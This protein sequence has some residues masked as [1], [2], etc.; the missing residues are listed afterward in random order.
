MTT[1]KTPNKVVKISAYSTMAGAFLTLANESQA[2]VIY[3]NI[4]D[5]TYTAIGWYG[6]DA[7]DNGYPDFL[8]QAVS[9]EGGN[10]TFASA[11]GAL[12]S[13]GYGNDANMVVGY[14]GDVHYYGSALNAGELIG[15]LSPFADNTY[16]R[17]WLASVYSGSTYGQFGNTGDRFMGFKFDIDG[18]LHYGWARL[19]ITL[20]PVTV[21]VK[22]YAYDDIPNNPIIAGDLGVSCDV[23]DIDG[24]YNIMPTSAKLKWFA[25]DAATKYQLKYRKVGT[26]TWTKLNVSGT[27]KTITGLECNVAYE[28]NVKS[29]CGDLFSA[30]SPLQ[31]FTTAVCKIGE[32]SST[33]ID[34]Y[35]NPA[36]DAVYLDFQGLEAT[37]IVSISDINGK[38]MA[39]DFIIEDGIMQVDIHDY[40]AG[41]YMM[42]IQTSTVIKTMK[43]VKQ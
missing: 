12:S 16:N 40:P 25:V 9:A 8:M 41:I 37:S 28:W 11:I 22:G 32:L 18:S 10:W 2:A 39:S 20:N 15:P 13:S 3:N 23:P 5:H 42:Q 7:D 21:T 27:Q 19:N 24:T 30:F 31:T 29:K 33:E 6:L 36:S 17:A 34:A 38:Q 1:K 35:P 14:L 26:A 4:D 43:F